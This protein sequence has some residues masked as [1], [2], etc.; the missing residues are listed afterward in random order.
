MPRLKKSSH[1]GTNA[2]P[3]TPLNLVAPVTRRISITF[4]CLSLL[5]SPLTLSFVHLKAA[6][7]WKH[8]SKR[9]AGINNG[10]M[11]KIYVW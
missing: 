6:P 11:R 3:V 4:R 7:A 1:G 2:E 9:V 10:Q 8:P 5:A